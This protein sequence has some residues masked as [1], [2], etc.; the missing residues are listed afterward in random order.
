MTTDLQKLAE[1]WVHDA[2]VDVSTIESRA[3]F[4]AAVARIESALAAAEKALNA[5]DKLMDDYWEEFDSAD[6]KPVQKDIMV[7]LTLLREP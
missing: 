7:A 6:L 3:A 4:L 1:A 2:H 5:A